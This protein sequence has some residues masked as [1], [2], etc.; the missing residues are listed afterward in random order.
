LVGKKR[1]EMG[2][3]AYKRFGVDVLILDDGFQHLKVKR[4]VDI[5][6]IDTRRGF[7]NGWLFPR[8]PLRE[9]LRCL[10]RASLFV[11]TKTEAA[12]QLDEITGVLRSHAPA[13]PLY[14]SRYKPVSLVEAATG[15][16]FPPQS[17]HGK[18]VLAFAGVADPD[19]FVHVLKGLGA[20]IVRT[21]YLPD[22]YQYT[23]ENIRTIGAYRDTVDLY[24]TTEK[25]YVK[26]QG[27]PLE[28][29]PLFVLTIEQ[30][31]LE[32]AF[33]QSVI[34]LLFP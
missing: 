34:S 1:Y 31:I 16:T 17:V 3:H 24:V 25:D 18:R 7:G 8:G 23:P 13:V 30:E 4:E 28:N 32:E 6:L 26:L 15:K 12:Q 10:R 9:P 5:V 29:I 21:L 27:I 19:Y 2:M 11:L 14:H 33:Y 22:H 20:D